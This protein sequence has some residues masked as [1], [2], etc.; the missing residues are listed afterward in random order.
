MPEGV[1]FGGGLLEGVD[2]LLSN[3]R[4][5]GRGEPVTFSVL[6]ERAVARC[7]LPSILLSS[8]VRSLFLTSPW[9]RIHSSEFGA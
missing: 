2:V 6:R 8:L 1:F 4:K 5:G 7:H 9:I 3:K